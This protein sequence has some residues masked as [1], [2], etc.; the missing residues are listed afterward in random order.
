M[1]MHKLLLESNNFDLLQTAHY[2]YRRPQ[3]VIYFIF[4]FYIFILIAF[5]CFRLADWICH[6]NDILAATERL[7][8]RTTC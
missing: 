6:E 2:N 4:Y 3:R 1:H 5:F 8:R 7:H